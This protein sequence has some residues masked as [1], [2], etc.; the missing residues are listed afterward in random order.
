MRCLPHHRSRVCAPRRRNAGYALLLILFF[1]A[2]MG[3]TAA[4]V[5]PSA[6]QQ[7][8]REREEEL[9]WRGEQYARAVRLF[10]RKNGRFPNSTEEMA[11][12]GPNG[13]RYLRQEYKDPM[14]PTDG[15]WR[16]LRVGPGGLL[17]GSVRDRGP[18][19]IKPPS[20][21]SSQPA[22]TPSRPEDPKGEGVRSD[23]TL[24]PTPS[25]PAPFGSD[26][27]GVGPII[28]VASKNP[29]RS[30]KIYDGGETYREWEFFWDPSKEVAVPGQPGVPQVPQ[31]PRRPGQPVQPRP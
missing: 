2:V 25:T 10:F 23:P 3:I 6:L 17:L 16:F 1:V 29:R 13:L 19:S 26:S 18:F 14:N 30:I 21:T 24:A 15:S 28:G 20:D 9:I 7:G 31:T 27:P 5:A 8:R 11:K 22:K 4:A 12:P